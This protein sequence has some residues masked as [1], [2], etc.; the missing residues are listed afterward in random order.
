MGQSLNSCTH[1][2]AKCQLTPKSVADLRCYLYWCKFTILFQL[3]HHIANIFVVINIYS[4]SV[5]VVV[6]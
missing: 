2:K 5:I 4:L 1:G 6:D 3:Q